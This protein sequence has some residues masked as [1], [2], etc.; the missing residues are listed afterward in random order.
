[1]STWQIGDVSITK[2][3][4]MEK[5][6]PF[7]ALLP[8]AEEVVDEFEWLKPDFVTEEGRMKLSIHALLVESE[9]LTIIVDT[10]CGNNK[11][12]P[13]ATP[14]DNLQTD[15]MSELENSGYRSEDVDVVIS[16]HLHVDHVGWNT[17][18]VDGS[19]V[20]TFPNAEY[21]FVKDEL[22]H[23]SSEPQHYGPVFEDSVQPILDAGMATIIDVDYE[24]TGE[25]GLE[26]T[27]GHTPGHVSVTI[28]S[29]NESG[30]ITGDMT[31]HPVQFAKPDLAS[32]ADWNQDMSTATRHEA[33][34]RWSDG[35]LIIGTHFAGR[36]AGVLVAEGNSWRFEAV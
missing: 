23:W 34:E 29:Q 3:L 32:S 24:I 20:P 33:Y 14:F 13:G 19:W 31:H 5:H 35:R 25:I 8:G 28:N 6:W 30:L 26:L 11:Q 21:L 4:E 7:S 22:A 15:F 17:T 36:T 18:F 27:A 10:C 12:R 9:G 16:T 2:V 1:M